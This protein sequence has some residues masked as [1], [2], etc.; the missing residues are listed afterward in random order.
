MKTPEQGDVAPDFELPGTG[1]RTYRLSDY[2]GRKVVLAFYPADESAVCTRQLCSY[3]D[4]YTDLEAAGAVVLGISSQGPESHERFR[5]HHDFPFPLLSDRDRTVISQWG[6]RGLFGK[7]RRAV[8][9]VDEDGQIRY[10]HV[11]PTVLT[12]RKAKELLTQLT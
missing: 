9:I 6:L 4:A 8:F 2:R 5:A 11:S 10:A 1:D 3:R 12:Y 7:S